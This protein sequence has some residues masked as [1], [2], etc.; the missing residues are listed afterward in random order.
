ME[1]ADI[2][3]EITVELAKLLISEMQAMNVDWKQAFMRMQAAPESVQIKGSFV[4]PNEIH[5]FDVFKHRPMIHAFSHKV[6]ALQQATS[7]QNK[8]FCV[9]LLI[10][11]SGFNFEV[12]YEYKN[13]NRWAISKMN[14]ASGYPDELAT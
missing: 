13:Q 4:L 12:K 2:G 1:N 14:N 8:V 9:A 11:D 7:H 10:V 3:T 6:R 5:L